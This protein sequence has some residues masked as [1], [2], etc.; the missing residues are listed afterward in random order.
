MFAL[1][2][3]CVNKSRTVAKDFEPLMQQVVNANWIICLAVKSFG[4][5]KK[6]KYIHTT[7]RKPLRFE[8]FFLFF[9]PELHTWVHRREEA[10]NKQESGH[11]QGKRADI[12]KQD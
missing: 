12:P 11:Q 1:A 4:E 7:N 10:D 2:P 3:Y 9:S 5:K 8:N 6:K